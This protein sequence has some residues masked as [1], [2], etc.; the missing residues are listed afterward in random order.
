MKL[1]TFRH[2]DTV[3]IG[4]LDGDTVAPLAV[5]PELPTA[6]IDFVALGA[7]GLQ[8]VAALDASRI[9]LEDVQLLAPIRPRN[10]IMCVGKN[11]Y[12]HAREFAGSGFDAS[13]KQVV[14]DEP[15]IFTK[16]LS[17][18][19]DPG[20]PVV[21]SADP[22]GTSDYEGELAVVIG[23]GGFQ[24]S[25]ADAWEHVY[26][27]TIVNDVTIRDLQR[28]HV[29]F[30]IGKSAHTY[31]P[32]GPALV[33]ADEIADVTALRLQTRVNGEL[34]QDTT[35]KELIFDIPRLIAAISAA[36]LLEPG[37]VIATGTP[38]GVGLGFTPPKFLVPGDVME[39]SIDGLGTLVNQT[40]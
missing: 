8:R 31:C 21:V 2:A 7:E 38:V 33:T 4:R 40:V 14:P 3:G 36:V 39:V 17:S 25:E 35:I 26:G 37:D 29:Q 5:D 9:G 18:L 1:V 10:N 16:A 15:V 22:T 34:R 19:T 13:Q 20:A 30:F 32:M 27:Y 12:E 6:M 11:Y 24:I 28:K 23:P